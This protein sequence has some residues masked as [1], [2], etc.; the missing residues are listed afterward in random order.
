[1]SAAAGVT[2]AIGAAL[3][4]SFRS[5][6][7]GAQSQL[8]RLG[9]TLQQLSGQRDLIERHRAL[10]RATLEAGRAARQTRERVAALGRQLAA[11]TN[12]SR[13]LIR[14][15]Q[16][17]Q[18]AASAAANAHEQHRQELRQLG[19]QLRD[20]GIDTSR[21]AD[22][23]ARLG[24]SLQ[25]L[26]RRYDAL[27][28]VEQAR[29]ANAERRNALRGQLTDAVA[30]GAGLYGLIQPA[31]AFEQAMAKVGAITTASGAEMEALS[32][33]ARALGAS[34]S[35]S[36][37][38]AAEAMSFLGMAGF[39]TADIL[40]ATPGLLD[41]ATAG[42]MDLAASADIASNILSG[43][44][45]EAERIGM[46]GDVMA[47]TLST[48]NVD[49][50]MLGET[51][52]YV[53]PAA[54]AAGASVHEVAAMT[55]LLGNV[56]IQA[57]QAGTA[58]RAAYL[59][60]AS[61]AKEGAKTLQALGVSVF[62][63]EGRMRPMPALLQDMAAALKGASDEA[64]LHAV[65]T[66][67]G[68]EAASAGLEL[69]KQAGSGALGSYIEELQASEGAAATMAK[70]MG[71]TTA[72][73]FKALGS[74]LESLAISVGSVLLPPLKDGAN[75][76]AG[77]AGVVAEAAAEYPLLTKVV[78]G[79]VTALMALK[80]ASI[81]G[82]YAWTFLKGGFLAAKSAVL[83]FQAALTLAR[84]GIIATR[85]ASPVAAVLCR[86]WG[87]AILIIFA[88]E[89]LGQAI[90]AWYTSFVR[91][92]GVAKICTFRSVQYQV[93]WKFYLKFILFFLY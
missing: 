29:Q 47:R 52:K 85:T 3:S 83:S 68:A 51:M 42:S 5:A 71:D 10:G 57:S 56:G 37:S 32:R 13:A 11:T 34:T 44:G 8:G 74:A 65:S 39:K 31:V 84:S 23:Q 33:Q 90:K 48:A 66:L 15:Y 86:D 82:G 69:L 87:K 50:A 22:E 70:R 91:S 25:R 58:L 24:D 26:Q 62:D 45:L 20:A 61:P 73:S 92:R 41:L 63:A 59:R 27:G 81:A 40:A 30:L 75:A 46:V 78:V 19:Q 1:M 55:G 72:G 14:E 80:A 93:I 18:R 36:A 67:F 4:A 16:A 89:S 35:Y 88:G 38:E 43:F 6:I 2:V 64:R 76:L 7:G 49:M 79:S 77:I 54:S 17:A 9:S 60:L 53:A 21:L 12:P 28:R